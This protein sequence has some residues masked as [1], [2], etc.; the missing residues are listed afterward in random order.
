MEYELNSRCTLTLEA[1]DD[2]LKKLAEVGLDLQKGD[3]LG[4][5]YQLLLNG[6]TMLG[7]Q[8]DY[9]T[10]IQCHPA[11]IPA[12]QVGNMIWHHSK[13]MTKGRSKK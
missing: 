8:R 10:G 5:I 11:R 6:S 13:K 7:L 2:L 3:R 9:S 4:W 1:A 12:K